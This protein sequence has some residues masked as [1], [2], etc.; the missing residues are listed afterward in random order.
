MVCQHLSGTSSSFYAV[1]TCVTIDL[2]GPRA[3][4]RREEEHLSALYGK[5]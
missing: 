4:A 1:E 3:K 2:A 5:I